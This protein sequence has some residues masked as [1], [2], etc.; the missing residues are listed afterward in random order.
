LISVLL[1]ETGSAL[2]QETGSHILLDGYAETVEPSWRLGVRYRTLP[3]PEPPPKR[4]PPLPPPRP[5]IVGRAAILLATPTFRGS[6]TVNDDEL[7]LRLL[8][9]D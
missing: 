4:Q 1:Q 5:V 9:N 2:L 8:L 7:V 6:A 3:G